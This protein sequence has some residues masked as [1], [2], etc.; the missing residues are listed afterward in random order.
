MDKGKIFCG[1]FIM[2]GLIAIGS[3]ISGAVEKYR[4]YD[5]TVN[6]KGLCEKEVKADKVIWPVVY[7]VLANDIQTIY[8]QIDA[9]NTVIKSFLEEGG[10]QPE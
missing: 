1:I 2:I 5:R 4:E 10:I 6:V 8:D 9:N 7:K 3:H